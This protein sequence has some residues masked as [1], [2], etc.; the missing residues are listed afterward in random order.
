MLIDEKQLR[1]FILDSGLVS[2]ADI[3]AVEKDARKK[4]E[5]LGKA[6]ISAGKITEDDL[7]HMQAY[8]LGI[9]FVDLKI[10][11]LIL[12]FSYWYPNRLLARTM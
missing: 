7:R 4:K 11:K 1:D 2:K 6:L 8:I 5:S 3:E 9:P 12:M 10:K